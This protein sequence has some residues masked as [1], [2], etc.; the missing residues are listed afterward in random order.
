MFL[1]N[2]CLHVT[3][4][5]CREDYEIS[6]SIH[7]RQQN[8]SYDKPLNKMEPMNAAIKAAI[9]DGQVATLWCWITDYITV[10][11]IRNNHLSQ[12]HATG[13][14]LDPL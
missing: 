1:E 10:E 13:F 12:D 4:V 6:H 14:A 11:V 2:S 5:W 9:K 8:G 7:F 3:C